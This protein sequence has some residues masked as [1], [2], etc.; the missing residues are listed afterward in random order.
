[1]LRQVYFFKFNEMP[2]NFNGVK[3]CK[4]VNFN[5]ILHHVSFAFITLKYHLTRKVTGATQ[6]R[7]YAMLIETYLHVIQWIIIYFKACCL[8]YSY[9]PRT[10]LI[11]FN[12]I[13]K[14][15]SG[16]LISSEM[17]LKRTVFNQI[18]KFCIEKNCV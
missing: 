8:T 4:Q 14:Y 15:I 18:N 16:S 10:A 12:F 9:I 13:C 5:T 1:M 6:L 17:N 3:I 7:T 11:S 2:V